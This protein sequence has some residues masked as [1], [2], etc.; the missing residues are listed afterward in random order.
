MATLNDIKHALAPL[1]KLRVTINIGNRILAHQEQNSQAVSG[2][3]VDIANA[4]AQELDLD[5]EWIVVSKAAQSVETVT[6]GNADIGFFAVDPKRA[7]TIAF[8]KPYVHIPGS[9]LV[10]NSSP[11]QSNEEVDQAGHRVAVGHGSAYDLYLSRHLQQASIERVHTSD[12]VVNYFLDNDFEVAAN[13][14]Q[15]LMFDA[16]KNP[17]LRI[18]PGHFMKIKQAMGVA[19][20]RPSSVIEAVNQF[21]QSLKDTGRIAE[22]LEKHEIEGVD[23]PS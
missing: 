22:F 13:I 12:Q 10:K 21:L 19:Q 18:L 11:I 8:S 4:L 23:I 9:Y 20:E 17:G 14:R 1:G 7:E 6:Q 15:Q 3:S 2:V 16:T 5:I